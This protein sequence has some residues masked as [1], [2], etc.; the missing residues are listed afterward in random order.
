MHIVWARTKSE[1]F[2]KL[3]AAEG[4]AIAEHLHGQR[5]GERPKGVVFIKN[6]IAEKLRK[7]SIFLRKSAQNARFSYFF[8][9]NTVE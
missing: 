6:K 8:G 4:Q 3:S 7:I 5:P 9:Q 1:A 2:A